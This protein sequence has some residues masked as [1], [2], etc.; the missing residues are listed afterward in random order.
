[1][2]IVSF[3]PNLEKHLEVPD[4]QVEG[5]NLRQVLDACCDLNPALRGYILDDQ[6]SVRKHVA[7]FIDG[8]MITDKVTLGDPV[9]SE[10]SVFVMQ[11]LSGG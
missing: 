6:G 7:I 3:T 5:D 8:V 11:A 10:S 2:A 1:M 4:L 9:T